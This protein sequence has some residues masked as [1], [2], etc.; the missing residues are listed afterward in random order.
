MAKTQ[1]TVSVSSP[2]MQKISELEERVHYLEDQNLTVRKAL[3]TALKKNKHLENR[4]ENLGKIYLAL[5]CFENGIKS[6]TFSD[7]DLRVIEMENRARVGKS[8]K[9]DILELLEVHENFEERITVLETKQQE[10]LVD[11][12]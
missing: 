1:E 10:N 3:E 12:R 5:T 8:F 4:L 2:T 7:L 11:L 6:W 9:E